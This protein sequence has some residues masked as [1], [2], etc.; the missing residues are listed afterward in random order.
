M[1]KNL[2]NIF[3]WQGE[4]ETKGQLQLTGIQCRDDG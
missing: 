3:K 1:K 2:I 4:K